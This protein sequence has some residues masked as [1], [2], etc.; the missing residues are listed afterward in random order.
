MGAGFSS[1]GK[2]E[3]EPGYYIHLQPGN[4]SFLAGGFYMPDAEKLFKIRQE[5]DYNWQE[6]QKIVNGK[7]FAKTFTDGVK[8]ET[9]TRPPKG[10]DEN[11][12]A[13]DFIKMKSFIVS[14]S[15]TDAELQSDSFVKEA[16][17][18]FGVMKPL[19]D[20]MNTALH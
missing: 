14:K 17:K 11:N 12:P 20:F 19:I 13:I 6:W 18:T 7:S 10:Y 8:G 9:L 1:K 3:Q 5:I 16:G 4:K 2:M 15:F